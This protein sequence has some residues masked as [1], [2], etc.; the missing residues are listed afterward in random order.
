MTQFRVVRGEHPVFRGILNEYIPK[1][2]S[3]VYKYNPAVVDTDVDTTGL[4][5]IKLVGQDKH[6]LPYV[7]FVGEFKHTKSRKTRKTRSKKVPKT[8]K[9]RSKKVPKSR[10]TRK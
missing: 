4:P 3:H 9:T 7:V 5:P 6:G 8:R 2:G 10:K 1:E